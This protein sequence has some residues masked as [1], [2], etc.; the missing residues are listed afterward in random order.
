[1]ALAHR[2]VGDRNHLIHKVLNQGETKFS[3]SLDGDAVRNRLNRFRLDDSSR[4]Q[5][6]HER[7]GP[8]RHHADD[9]HVGACGFFTTAARP[10]M[11]PPP[12][13]GTRMV[14]T[15]GHFLQ[16]L[17]AQSALARYDVGMIERR[18]HRQAALFLVGTGARIGVIERRSEQLRLG[19]QGPHGVELGV[20]RGFGHHHQGFHAQLLRREGDALSVVPST[21]GDD[22]P[23]E[24]RWFEFLQR[25]QGAAHLE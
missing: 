18:Y 8:F 14:P 21:R 24:L 3:V 1:M 12:P 20:R 5:R 16:Y 19:A 22:A 10:E 17:E 7:R 9:A 25:V 23:L 15:S 11:R 6:T 13:T 4:I 2:I